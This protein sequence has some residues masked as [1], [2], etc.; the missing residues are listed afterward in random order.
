MASIENPDLANAGWITC[1]RSALLV[2]DTQQE[3]GRQIVPDASQT[4]LLEH[5]DETIPKECPLTRPM[6]TRKVADF[7]CCLSCSWGLVKTKG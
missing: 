2:I 6:M 1:E 7:A 3:G 5:R 4:V